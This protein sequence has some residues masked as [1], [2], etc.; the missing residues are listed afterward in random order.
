MSEYLVPERYADKS[1]RGCINTSKP[2]VSVSIVKAE[3]DRWDA[4]E[5][6]IDLLSEGDAASVTEYVEDSSGFR[7]LIGL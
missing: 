7:Y 4:V 5:A 3:A 2:K 6:R 1:G